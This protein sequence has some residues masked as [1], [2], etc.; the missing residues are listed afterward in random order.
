VSVK[1]IVS[2]TLKVTLSLVWVNVLGYILE[3]ALENFL[4]NVWGIAW[5][6]FYLSKVGRESLLLRLYFIDSTEDDDGILRL[7]RLSLLR[8]G[9]LE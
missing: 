4:S 5:G 6:T 7:Y 9:D 3:N 1:E 2:A 8:L